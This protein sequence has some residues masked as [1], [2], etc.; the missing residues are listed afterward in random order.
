VV[1]PVVL[2]LNQSTA[3]KAVVPLLASHNAKREAVYPVPALLPTTMPKEVAPPSL[4]ATA[5]S[6]HV[7]VVLALNQ[8]TATKAVVPL[9][10]SHNVRR[11]AAYPVPALLPPMMLKEAVLA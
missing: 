6:E 10:P 3:T 11:E 7:P 8:S 9:L 5:T 4:L 1:V 2:A